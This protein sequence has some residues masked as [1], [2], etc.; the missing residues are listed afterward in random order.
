MKHKVTAY[1]P[2]ILLFLLA[3]IAG[4]LSYKD[5]GIS[6]DEHWQRELGTMTYNYVFN[7]D[8]TLLTYAYNFYGSGFEFPLAC[9]EKWLKLTDARDVYMMRHLAAHIFFLL[10]ALS[11]YFLILKLFRNQF[12][13]CVG[14]IMLVCAPR[15]YAHSFFNSKDVVFLSAFLLTLSVSCWAFNKNKP[16]LYGLLGVFC[17][18]TTSIRIMGIML[19]AFVMFFLLLDWLSASR[20]KEDSKLPTR[21][22]LF[23]FIGFSVALYISWPYLWHNPFGNLATGFKAMSHYD[24]DAEIL[25]NGSRVKTT[26]LPWSYFPNWF[27]I[28]VPVLWLLAGAAGLIRIPVDFLKK[29][30]IFLQNTT[31]RNFLLYWLC[32]LVPILAVIA[33]HSVIYDDWRHLYFVYPSFVLVALYF[34]N[35]VAERLK[36]NL[37]YIVYGACAIQAVL[38]VLFM[39][40]NHPFQQVYFNE[41]VSHEPESLRE[42]YELEYWGASFKQGLEHIVSADTAKTIHIACNYDDPCKNNINM[43][44]EADRKRIE[45]V[46]VSQISKADYFITNYRGHPEDYPSKN[47]EYSAKVL[48]STIMAVFK[49]KK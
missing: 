33:M 26:Q 41:L 46:P 30:S 34:I 28:T 15:I 44:K 47:I 7:G 40:Q 16:L 45:I 25:L 14:F 27:I 23:C 21:N 37:T 36:G 10:S 2:G 22:L 11:A 9:L 35:K 42:N 38:V 31:E 48:N 49:L 43:L 4:V 20:K 5:Y 19:F 12:L 29:P 6:W 17:G 32:F 13:A 18:Y 1:V 39:V 3:L 8:K 24:W